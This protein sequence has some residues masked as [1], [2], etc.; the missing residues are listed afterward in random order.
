[1]ILSHDPSLTFID[2]MILGPTK[3][4][5]ITHVQPVLVSVCDKQVL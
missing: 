2:H 5:Q 1:M 3:T 4:A